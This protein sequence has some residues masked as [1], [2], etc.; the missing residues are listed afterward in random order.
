MS[1]SE[2]IKYKK[3][4]YRVENRTVQTNE[5]KWSLF[6]IHGKDITNLAKTAL[7]LLL[8]RLAKHFLLNQLYTADMRHNNKNN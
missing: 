4:K 7:K 8:H 1:F 5:K 3:F 2:N 6:K